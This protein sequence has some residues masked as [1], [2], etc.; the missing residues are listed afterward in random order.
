MQERYV[1]WLPLIIVEVA[2]HGLRKSRLF[3]LVDEQVRKEIQ[4]S[5]NSLLLPCRWVKCS[6]KVRPSDQ[7]IDKFK[8]SQVWNWQERLIIDRLCMNGMKM[9]GMV[10]VSKYLTSHGH[11]DRRC[12]KR[13]AIS[14][15]TPWPWWGRQFAQ[16]MLASMLKK[17]VWVYSKT[18]LKGHMVDMSIQGDGFS[19]FLTHERWAEWA[20]H[21]QV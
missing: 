2:N 11:R 7:I 15:E 8:W 21:R 5:T 19:W 6:G 12:S 1:V 16:C 10:R 14:R 4:Y 9:I 3:V 20:D 17:A 13:K 18:N